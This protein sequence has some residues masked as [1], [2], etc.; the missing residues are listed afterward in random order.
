MHNMKHFFFFKEDNVSF[1][2]FLFEKI[3]VFSIFYNRR[4]NKFKYGL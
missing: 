4:Q 2:F 1:S 3:R